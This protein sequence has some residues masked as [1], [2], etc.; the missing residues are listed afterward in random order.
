MSI[1]EG[2]QGYEYPAKVAWRKYVHGELLK[3]SLNLT[4]DG[5]LSGL[6]LEAVGLNANC[7]KQIL[8]AGVIAESQLI[9][10][11]LD[12]NNETRSK[13]NISTCR[14]LFSAASFYAE[15]FSAY[16]YHTKTKVAYMVYDVFTSTHGDAFENN[17]RACFTLVTS[18]L[19]ELDQVLLVI[20]ADVGVAVR[21]NK[22]VT[23]F[24][25]LVSGIGAMYDIPK[26]DVAG[27]EMYEYQ[28]TPTSTRMGTIVLDFH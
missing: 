18:S 12:P 19:T 1:S 2:S 7:F 5:K 11:D 16:C 20:N 4:E 9:G 17:L 28:N 22:T 6:Y 10:L 3:R 23:G 14:K 13:K 27:A 25:K 26:V 24:R 21:H 8:N 15:T